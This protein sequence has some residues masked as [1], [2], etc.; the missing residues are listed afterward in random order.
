ML[1]LVPNGLAGVRHFNPTSTPSNTGGQKNRN[2][3][4]LS[5]YLVKVTSVSQE[6]GGVSGKPADART[7]RSSDGIGVE[8]E[9]HAACG[10]TNRGLNDCLHS[11]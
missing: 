9:S 11:M 4:A 6:V 5:Q 1:R 8:E 2:A 10:S 3:D 7:Q